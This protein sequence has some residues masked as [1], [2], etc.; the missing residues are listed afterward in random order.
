MKIKYKVWML[1]SS[2]TPIKTLKRCDE[3][4]EFKGYSV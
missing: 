2:I 4:A 3:A 1:E